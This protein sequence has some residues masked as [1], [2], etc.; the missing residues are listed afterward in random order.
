[1]SLKTKFITGAMRNGIDKIR[2]EAFWENL[3]AFGQYG[4]NKSHSIA[5]A[6]ITYQTAWLKAHYPSEFMASLIS[7]ESEADQAAL[8]IEN[9]KQMGINVL[10]PDINQSGR[11]FSISL[12][13]DI[14]F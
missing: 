8:Y 10:P 7:L 2:L 14:L 9:A 3:L 1:M 5:Y 13:G 11:D 4:F 12:S 6:L